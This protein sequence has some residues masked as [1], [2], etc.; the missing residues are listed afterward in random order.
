MKTRIS[1]VTNFIYFTANFH[2]GYQAVIRA[3][4]K[5]D[6][7]LAEHIL[8]KLE[9]ILGRKYAGIGVF[10]MGAWIDL[11]FELDSANQEKM[12]AWIELN[13]HHNREHEHEIEL[14]PDLYDYL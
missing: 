2:G 10:P 7:H 3:M 5:D 11:F 4:W 9:S 14:E 6:P 1:A 13:Y 12:I 8:V